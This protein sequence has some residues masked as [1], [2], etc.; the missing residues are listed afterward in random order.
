V[1]VCGVF[2][3][4][5]YSVGRNGGLRPGT[6]DTAASPALGD[7]SLKKPSAT[8]QGLTPVP[9]PTAATNPD[10]NN[11]A[12]S[13][14]PNTVTETDLG[15]NPSA[16]QTTPAQTSAPAAQPTTATPQPAATKPVPPTQPAAQKSTPSPTPAPQTVA[17]R[18]APAAA[19]KPATTFSNPYRPATP[20][21]TPQN[22]AANSASPAPGGFMVQIAAVRQPQDANVLVSALQQHGF[23]AMVRHEAQDQLLHVQLGPFATRAEAFNM[24]SKLL[25]NGYNAV[26]K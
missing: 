8:E 13:N 26:V 19:A 11:A 25:A 15:S 17:Q 18:P 14:K 4:L 3:G 20:Q 9:T 24:R 7:S 21:P 5:G 6:D 1:L 12:Q 23:H 2:F 10:Q 22:Y 16:N